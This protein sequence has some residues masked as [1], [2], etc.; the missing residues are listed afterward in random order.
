[1]ILDSI[2]LDSHKEEKSQFQGK[3]I[4]SHGEKESHVQGKDINVRWLD[5]SNLKTYS[6]K[7]KT[8]KAIEQSIPCQESSSNSP[9]ELSLAPNDLDIPIS[10]RKGVRSY[11][12]HPLS[13]FVCY[14]SLS[15]SYI[16][17]VLSIS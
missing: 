5:R 7:E 4:D 8:D 16:A 9:S 17:F 11:I 2:L 13:N 3:D 14:G 6:R 12:N 15:P 10:H 1:M